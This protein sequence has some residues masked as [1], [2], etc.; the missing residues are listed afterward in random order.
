MICNQNN[1]NKLKPVLIITFFILIF[2][3]I[4]YSNI[5]SKEKKSDVIMFDTIFEINAPNAGTPALL[6]ARYWVSKD[7]YS[8]GFKWA[9][10]QV[11]N[12]N[13]PTYPP[14][15][16]ITSNEKAFST[17]SQVIESHNDKYPKPIE[18]RGVFRHALGSYPFRNI[19]FAER[20]ALE[21]RIYTKDIAGISEPDSN[22]LQTVVIQDSKEDNGIK[23]KAARL[24]IQTNNGNITKLAVAD[25]NGVLLK[26]VDYEY[27]EHDG[28]SMLKHQTIYLPEKRL[29]VG[30][31][32]KG[33]SITLRGQ[34]KT[35]KE[36]PGF[37]HTGA[38]K[39]DIEYETIKTDKGPLSVP[40]GIVVKKADVN[41]TLRTA[42]MSNFTQLKM[43]QEEAQKQAFEFS[44]LSENELEVRD[45]LERYWLKNPDD[46]ND[47][48][49]KHLVQLRREF[50]NKNSRISDTSEKLKNFSMLLS[51]DWIQDDPNLYKDF[52]QY[53][54][55]LKE[56]NFNQMILLGGIN[57]IDMTSRWSRYSDADKLLQKW[58]ENTIPLFNPMEILN[59]SEIQIQD[60]KYWTV[61][62]LLGNYLKS[63]NDLGEMRFDIQVMRYMALLELNKLIEDPSKIKQESIRSQVEWALNSMK[64]EDLIRLASDSLAEAQETFS[65]LKEPNEIQ[66]S[67]KKKLD[68][69]EEQ[70]K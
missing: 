21:S 23:R 32:G 41:Y 4:I 60:K 35:Y 31:S 18:E 37:H 20:D 68:Q 61:I 2:T 65:E 56:N 5:S 44:R 70:V 13:F 58:I 50:E 17:T 15:V 22:E 45:L 24:N 11:G 27:S 12:I 28:K 33:V 54:K 25:S 34:K 38:R 69:I 57:A 1:G 55:I 6:F 63:K 48:D 59:F 10:P 66:M 30:Y 67:I 39:C 36:L 8:I 26:G 3:G 40:A 29:M 52:E 7:F 51:L 53:L 19:R 46:I 62:N 16:T 43:T 14:G 47:I 64:K 42:K 49:T 9:E